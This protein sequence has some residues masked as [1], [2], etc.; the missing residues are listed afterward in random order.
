VVAADPARLRRTLG[1]PALAR[2]VN[3][4]SRRLELGRPLEADLILEGVTDAER[5]A[6]G[7]MLGRQVSGHG[8]SV[9]V[10]PPALSDVLLRAG[11]APDLR[12]AVELLA[13]PV[14]SRSQVLAAEQAARDAA[15]SV[16]AGGRP[17]GEAWYDRWAQ[18]LRTDGTLTRLVRAGAAQ[19]IRQAVGV[20][21]FLPAD[22]LPLPVLAERAT[23]DTKALANTPLA[24]LVLRALALR[25]GTEPASLS[26]R[27]VQRA[28]WESVG[29]I[30]DDLASQ[31]L[32]LG[33][34]ASQSVPLGRWL[35]EAAA[36]GTPLR[37]TLHQLV[38]MPV[39]PTVAELFVC[40]NPSVLRAAVAAQVT[41]PGAAAASP[42]RG[43]GLVC[44]EGI[45]SSACHRLLSAC[46]R[47]DV[48]IRWRGDFDWTGLRTVAAAIARYDA[49]PWR[50]GL[51]AYEEA[52]AV[53]CTEPLK[54]SAAESPWDPPLATRMAQTGRAV[55][56]ERLIPMLLR[57][58]STPA[59]PAY[60]PATRSR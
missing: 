24:R 21:S 4:L 29:V 20:L 26:R 16:I 58:L 33:L 39:E 35:S 36:D 19:V 10:S 53:G 46:Q 59:E 5:M 54:G 9:R 18:S 41:V 25:E 57:D 6:L 47:A 1:D 2:L 50:M 17:A 40:E 22:A 51:A 32:V 56:E 44:T 55:M 15:W 48:V 30:P 43:L 42:G 52:L 11:I 38:T 12:T 37:V 31:V 23:G 8:R 7:R 3:R 34:T 14:T 60:W 13:G 27:E 45:P 28:L 49:R